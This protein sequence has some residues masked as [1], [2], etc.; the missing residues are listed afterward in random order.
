MSGA[1][2]RPWAASL[3][4]VEREDIWRKDR[5]HFLHPWTHFDSFKQQ[6]SLVMGRGE[7]AY[8]YDIAGKR[9]LDGIGGLWCVNLGYGREEIVSAIAEQARRL[10]FFNS[11]VDTTNVPA[12]E[13]AA[14]L[15]ALAPGDLNH[16]FFTSGGSTANDTAVRL[17]HYY[18]SRCGRSEKRHVIARID[19]YH[20]S[21]YLTGSLSGKPGDRSPHLHFIQDWVHHVASPN[22]Y[23]RPKGMSEAAFCDE[24]LRELE[25]K[26]LAIGPEKVAAFFAE[27][28]LGAGGVIVPPEGYN[29]RSRELCRRYEVLYVADEVVT[30]FGRLG[31]MF[32]SREVFGIE[33]D[34]LVC[35]KGLTSGYQPLGA[36]IYSDAIHEVISAPDPEAWFT[37]G[38]TYSGHPVAC[39]AGLATIAV[40]ERDDICGH[41]RRLGP[42][43]EAKLQALRDLPIVG[44]VRGSH[45]MMCVE[46][47][48]DAATGEP[49]P[50]SVDIGK[51][52]A[53]HCERLGLIV[54][55]IGP[56]NIISPPLILGEAE[57][58]SLAAILRRGI[59]AT[60][61]DLRAEGIWRD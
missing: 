55:P 23:R 31:H 46:N 8:V 14:R 35:A 9:Y 30:G 44:D 10:A 50:D 49:F 56:L 27:P 37:N 43:L 42:L 59:E 32:A 61:R 5:D 3:D 58:E 12:A 41:V 47:V 33:P 21:T 54:R 19:G 34:I 24:L 36:C 2:S 53:D 26:I 7:G 45:F 1:G 57:I 17:I 25:A 22:P 15:A 16:V 39:A 40:M 6:G 18:Q 13:L 20:G 4:Q 11:F 60:M 52:I 29:R 48:A 51:R 28:V 38:F